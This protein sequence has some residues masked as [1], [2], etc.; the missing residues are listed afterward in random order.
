MN[1]SQSLILVVSVGRA[2]ALICVLTIK[3][4]CNTKLSTGCFKFESVRGT[5]EF[6]NLLLQLPFQP[7]Q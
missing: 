1:I 2:K 7:L 3:N 6:K 5:H 4:I